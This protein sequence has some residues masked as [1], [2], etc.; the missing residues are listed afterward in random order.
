MRGKSNRVAAVY[1]RQ[2]EPPNTHRLDT[3]QRERSDLLD[4]SSKEVSAVSSLVD[5]ERFYADVL[6][7]LGTHALKGGSPFGAAV[8]VKRVA[9]AHGLAVADRLPLPRATRAERE[10]LAWW[11]GRGRT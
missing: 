2:V 6:E 7:A 1:R 10:D 3:Y 9:K 5:I 11:S 8:V 4:F